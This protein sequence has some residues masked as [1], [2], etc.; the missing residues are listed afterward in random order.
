V[1]RLEE[2]Q[3]A[4]AVARVS[5]VLDDVKNV[6]SAIKKET[7]RIERLVEW[8]FEGASRRRQRTPDPP[9]RVM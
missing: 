2:R 5:A 7:G 9:N 1:N 6:T 4:P 3:I 8:V